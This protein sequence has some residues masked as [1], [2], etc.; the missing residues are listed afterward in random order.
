V[1]AARQSA[2]A[3]PA[4]APAAPTPAAAALE[5]LSPDAIVRS[6]FPSYAGGGGGGGGLSAR[7]SDADV[8]GAVA[9]AMRDARA[10]LGLSG[11]EAP[12]GETSLAGVRAAAAAAAQAAVGSPAAPAPVLAQAPAPSALA[13]MSMRFS[14][15]GVAGAV[16]A[17]YTGGSADS[18]GADSYELN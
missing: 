15:A 7:S 4:P 10:I 3:A 18:D 8:E 1:S 17:R 9:E 6:V 11:R 14:G 13:G 5:V 2:R 16:P 12:P